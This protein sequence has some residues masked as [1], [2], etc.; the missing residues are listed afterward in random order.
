MPVATT[1]TPATIAATIDLNEKLIS[2]TIQ[3]ALRYATNKEKHD[4]IVRTLD[5][6]VLLYD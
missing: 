3:D 4:I 6:I 5:Q 1:N 2:W